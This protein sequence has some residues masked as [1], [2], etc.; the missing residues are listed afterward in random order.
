MKKLLVLLM[1]SGLAAS[2]QAA[3]S[4]SLNKTTIAVGETAVASVVSNDASSWT[5]DFVLSEDTYN[6][7][8]PVAAAYD[9]SWTITSHAGDLGFT[10]ATTY[11][12]VI[13]LSAGGTTTPPSSGTQFSINIKGVQAGTIYIDLQDDSTWAEM[14]NGPLTL[15]VTP[16]PMTMALL[17]LGGLFLRPPFGDCAAR[18]GLR[19]RK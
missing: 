18:A 11:P 2:A 7:T 1:V 10:E 19:R 4:L 16:E 9:G 8:A 5:N 3:L 14:A 12:A 17:G 15:T 13:K 6:W